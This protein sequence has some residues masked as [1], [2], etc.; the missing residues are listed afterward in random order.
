[1]G[2]HDPH[3][4]PFFALIHRNRLPKRWSGG[5]ACVG[6]RDVLSDREPIAP[7]HPSLSRSVAAP[8]RVGGPQQGY[9]V[10]FQ[11]FGATV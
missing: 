11:S 4:R 6:G 2:E 1:M 3:I 10:L 5:L 9:R 8:A 7:E